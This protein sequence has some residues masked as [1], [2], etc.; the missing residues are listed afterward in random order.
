MHLSARM[1]S[2]AS[3]LGVLMVA[4]AAAAEERAM[5]LQAAVDGAGSLTATVGPLPKGLFTHRNLLDRSKSTITLTYNIAQAGDC[6]GPAGGSATS[7]AQGTFVPMLNA[8]GQTTAY[9]WTIT[10]DLSGQQNHWHNH[11]HCDE[12]VHVHGCQ[13][14]RDVAIEV[15]LNNPGDA[16]WGYDAATLSLASVQDPDDVETNCGGG[17][18]C[19]GPALAAC[20]TA[21]EQETCA[22]LKGKARAECAHACNCQCHPAANCPIPGNCQD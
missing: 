5:N 18:G 3:L 10:I 22:D 11:I 7:T 15:R 16:E 12:S 19:D 13:Q 8:Q 2:A 17:N 4:Q 20:T 21:C 6:H 14:S 9:Y 1:L